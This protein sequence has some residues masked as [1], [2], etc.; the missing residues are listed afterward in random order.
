MRW[1]APHPSLTLTGDALRGA[2]L[3]FDEDGTRAPECF[4]D[5]AGGNDL[6]AGRTGPSCPAEPV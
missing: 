4:W 1:A 5:V 3:S 2:S 6:A